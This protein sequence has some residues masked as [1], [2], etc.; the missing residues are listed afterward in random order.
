MSWVNGQYTDQ[1][2]S[3]SR[4]DRGF[5]LGD[6]VFETI[7]IRNGV[8]VFLGAHLDRLE[9]GLRALQIPEPS[10]SDMKGVFCELVRRNSLVAENISGRL[11]VSRGSRGRG[12]APIQAR[13]GYLDTIA[14]ATVLVSVTPTAESNAKPLRLFNTARLRDARFLWAG[15]KSISGY[16][17]NQAARFEAEE[18]G[19]DEGLLVNLA[20]RIACAATANLFMIQED[21]AVLTP[22][23]SEGAMPGVTRQVIMSLARAEDISMTEAPI[24]MAGLHSASAIFL[25][26]SLI[27]VRQAVLGA[28][29]ALKN[30]L[31]ERLAKLYQ[32]KLE[33]A[34]AEG[35]SDS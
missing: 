12:L 6:G 27:G 3:L 23:L 4:D 1:D 19:F 34:Y 33:E 18:A 30:P 7:L 11:T 13:S 22:P 9:K 15:F 32:S 31:L 21:G 10:L 29:E 17:E 26:N 16:A 8:P 28:D 25:S 5:L 14:P 35:R 20:G 24:T 2:I